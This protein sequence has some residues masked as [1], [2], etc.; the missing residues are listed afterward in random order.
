MGRESNHKVNYKRIDVPMQYRRDYDGD[1][2]NASPEN[3]ENLKRAGHRAIAAANKPSK[4]HYTLDEIIAI[5]VNEKHN[6]P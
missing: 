4:D 1:M 5:I 6:N 2:T 3:I